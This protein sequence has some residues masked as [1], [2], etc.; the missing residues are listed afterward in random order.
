[1]RVEVSTGNPL[2]DTEA[3]SSVAEDV[4][5]SEVVDDVLV[6]CEDVVDEDVDEDEVV[7]DVDVVVGASDSAPPVLVP[8][9]RDCRI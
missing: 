7:E 2:W 4:D 1:V 8:R 5:E 6:G 3:A 9:C